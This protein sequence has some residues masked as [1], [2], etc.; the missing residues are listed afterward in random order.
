M[1]TNRTMPPRST[2][3]IVPM[4]EKNDSTSER[5]ASPAVR[6]GLM[7]FESDP[8]TVPWG[9]PIGVEAEVVSLAVVGTVPYVVPTFR[10]GLTMTGGPPLFRGMPYVTPVPCITMVV[11]HSSVIPLVG[12]CVNEYACSDHE[13]DEAQEK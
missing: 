3:P 2:H 4:P 10:G 1:A 5:N 9:W 12:G 6:A 7:A 13:Q 8:D 11:S